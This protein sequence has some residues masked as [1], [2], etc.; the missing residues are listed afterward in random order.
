[1]AVVTAS[2]ATQNIQSRSQICPVRVRNFVSC[3]TRRNKSA[4]QRLNS[5][6]GTIVAVAACQRV[7][8]RL[9]HGGGDS[10]CGN[11]KHI[12]QVS[13]M[14]G[15][16]KELRKLLH[17]TQQECRTSH[18]QFP[19]NDC[20]AVAAC[21]RVTRRLN[22]GG[23]DSQCGNSKHTEQISSMPS[24]SKELR[25]LLHATQQECSTAPQQFPRNDCL[26]WQHV[27]ASRAG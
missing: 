4:A 19:R 26:Q 14:P 13:N 16:S 25:K 23:G 10:Q 1:M 15:Q 11:T 27:S 17:S 7:T 2:V 21:Q 8:R 3:C 5:F 12:E 20:F 9:S 22:H 24:Q 6:R 18:Q